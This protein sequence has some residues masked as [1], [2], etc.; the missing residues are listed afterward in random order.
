MRHNSLALDQKTTE[1][2]NV[3]LGTAPTSQNLLWLV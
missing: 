2:L 3:V 1:G